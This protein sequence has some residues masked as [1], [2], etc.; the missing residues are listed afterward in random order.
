MAPSSARRRSAPPP[1]AT[2]ATPG[3]YDVVVQYFDVNTGAARYQ[4]RVAEAQG[5]G[6]VRAEWTANDRFPMRKLDGGSST[7]YI[8]RNVALKTGDRIMV[9]GTPEG[10][11]RRRSIM[12]R[13]G[14]RAVSAIPRQS[15]S[16]SEV[17]DAQE[18]ALR[19]RRMLRA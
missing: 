3:R 7:R 18:R 16:A 2:P 13:L 4:V 14:R 10:A 19:S 1:S 6:A 8:L 15:S 5:D 9:E 17:R 12:W 11:R